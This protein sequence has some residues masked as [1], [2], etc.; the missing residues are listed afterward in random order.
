MADLLEA[1]PE[2]SKTCFQPL[3]SEDHQHEGEAQGGPCQL[4]PQEVSKW[5]LLSLLPSLI[6][7]SQLV[8]L[9]RETKQEGDCFAS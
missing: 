4:L 9:W 1:K 8:E 7:K 6:F 3:N 5:T 2:T